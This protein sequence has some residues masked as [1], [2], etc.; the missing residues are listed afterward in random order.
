MPLKGVITDRTGETFTSNKGE[1]IR[2]LEYFN[3]ENC[4]IIFNEKDIVYNKIYRHIKNGGVNNPHLLS[5]HNVGFLGEG[6]YKSI[7]NRKKTIA[8]S[9]WNSML[10]RCYSEKLQEKHPTYKGCSVTKEWHNFQNFAKWYEDNYNPKT[11]KGWDLDKDILIKGNKVYSPETSCFVPNEVNTIFISCKNKRGKHPIGVSFNK[12][13][14]IFISQ[15]SLEKNKIYL[16]SFNTPEEA[17]QTYKIFKEAYIKE[18]ADK[19][20]DQ[21]TEQVYQAMYNYKVEIT[22]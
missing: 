12:Q 9:K 19:W 1:T 22:D 20:K 6:V 2:I 21:I 3:C 7:N 14:K 17:F 5:V 16:G 18:T 15:T 4:T 11:M 10:E 8:Y 13:N